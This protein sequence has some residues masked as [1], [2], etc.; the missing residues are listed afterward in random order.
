[1]ER[2]RGGARVDCVFGMSV[3][4]DEGERQI[5]REYESRGKAEVFKSFLCNCVVWLKIIYSIPLKHTFLERRPFLPA[6]LH[7]Y[8]GGYML[9]KL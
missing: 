4:V 9:L 2:I 1:M 7:L 5:W 8:D 6:V 3:G